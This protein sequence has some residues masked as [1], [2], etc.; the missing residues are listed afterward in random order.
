MK[1]ELGIYLTVG[2]SD[3]PLLAKSYGNSQV[4]SRDYR[5]QAEIEIVIR[6]IAEQVTARIRAHHKAALSIGY[7]F[8]S[9]EE[10]CKSSFG[11]SMK[12]DTINDNGLLAAHAI[13]LF[14]NKWEGETVRN[15]SI[16]CADLVNDNVVQLDLFDTKQ[17]SL[18]KES[19]IEP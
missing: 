3:N 13:T 5:N 4:L 10:T 6:G 15:I 17:T 14:R 8:R 2:I 18:K 9:K 1:E 16:S 7:S 11:H 12:I 19:L